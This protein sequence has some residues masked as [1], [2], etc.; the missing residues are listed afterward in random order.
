VDHLLVRTA[1]E[2]LRRPLQYAADI[3]YLFLA[4][5]EFERTTAGLKAAL[6]PVSGDG[7]KA[8]E[9]GVLCYRSQLSSLFDSPDA[10]M[11]S[12]ARYAQEQG[13]IRLWSLA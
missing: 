2:S 9:E 8:W 7:M 10:M 11:A 12:I 6:H 3:P 5:L 13:G 1:L 4:P